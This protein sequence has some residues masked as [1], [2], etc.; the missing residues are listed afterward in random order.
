MI[1][2]SLLQNERG[3][4]LCSMRIARLACFVAVYIGGHSAFGQP[5]AV[6]EQPKLGKLIA[7]KGIAVADLP[8]CVYCRFT[9]TELRLFPS[10]EGA[11]RQFNCGAS[12]GRQHFFAHAETFW[13]RH[14]HG[15]QRKFANA[16]ANP[17]DLLVCWGLPVISYANYD[18]PFVVGIQRVEN[19]A[20]AHMDISSQLPLRRI[21]HRLNGIAGGLGSDPGRLVGAY[22]KGD[23]DG[24]NDYQRP[25]EY[26]EPKR[27]ARQSIVSL[28]GITNIYGFAFGALC[29]GIYCWAIVVSLSGNVA[30]LLVGCWGS[31]AFRVTDLR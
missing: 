20:A 1:A 14:N 24:G 2:I 18:P 3:I 13:R 29:A 31:T 25:G 23:L 15:S 6:G 16:R 17:H 22:Q 27:I 30:L 8:G 19:F 12:A 11:D 9:F 10:A 7:A 26:S 21:S 5:I 28:L 4:K